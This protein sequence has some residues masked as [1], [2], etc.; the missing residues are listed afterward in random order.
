MSRR[1]YRVSG[2]VQGVGFRWACQRA[3]RDIGVFGWA[4][5]LDSGEVEVLAEGD[6]DQLNQ[7]ETWLAKGPAA[8]KVSAVTPVDLENY[9]RDPV[10][11][12]FEIRR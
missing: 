10:G 1:R 6:A 8:A 12:S 4:R 3:A 2:R 11:A 5:N 9:A 7:L